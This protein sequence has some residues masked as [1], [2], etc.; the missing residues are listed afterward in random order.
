MG[1]NNVAYKI[2]HDLDGVH[3]D[4]AKAVHELTGITYDR[5]TKKQFWDAVNL[6]PN[7]FGDLPR[8]HD[9]EVLLAHTHH[10][11]EAVLTA[12][13]RRHNGAD[14]KRRWVKQHLGDYK[15]IV[16]PAKNKADYAAPNHILIDDTERNIKW[17]REA[18]GIGILHR[19]AEE[20]IF[21][22]NK[23]MPL[24]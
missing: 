1:C 13:P 16:V 18:G 11:T 14:Q 20:T 3:A 21:E 17:W 24:K 15:V 4:I 2:F 5:I 19:S 12:L 23:L 10:M 8:L 22:L 7:F 6:E 9:S